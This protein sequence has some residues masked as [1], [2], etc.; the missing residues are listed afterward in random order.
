[1]T[2][3]TVLWR[4]QSLSVADK[5]RYAGFLAARHALDK[6]QKSELLFQMQQ[7]TVDASRLDRAT[8]SFITSF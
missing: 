7:S 6:R 8:L 5:P 1:L 2:D 4:E 3:G